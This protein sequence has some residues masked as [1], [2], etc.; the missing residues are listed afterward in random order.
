MNW[1]IP[2]GKFGKQISIKNL[3]VVLI[4]GFVT[5]VGIG[6]S[7]LLANEDNTENNS[8]FEKKISGSL[9]FWRGN[10]L[11]KVQIKSLNSFEVTYTG[12]KI[13]V[14]Y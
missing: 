11:Y 1:R 5:I 2:K 12:G 14:V 8:D 3:L 13:K 7:G 4:V 6:I 10:N 9:P